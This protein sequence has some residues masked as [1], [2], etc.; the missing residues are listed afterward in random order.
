[1]MVDFGRRVERKEF[2][3][4]MDEKQEMMVEKVPSND[5]D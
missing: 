3:Q 4:I 2:N 5:Y 1:M